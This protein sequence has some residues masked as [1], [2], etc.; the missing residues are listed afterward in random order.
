MSSVLQVSVLGPIVFNVFISDID[1]GAEC[2]LSKFADDTKLCDAVNAPEGQ[3]FIQKDL[4]RLEH[5]AWVN[6]VRFTKS[7]CKILNLA[8]GIP[9]YQYKLG[10]EKI[11]CSPAKKDLEVL[12]GS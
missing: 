3:D 2:T 12:V 5:W 9:C 10:K 4:A 1:S 11:E 7:N 6:L 8:K